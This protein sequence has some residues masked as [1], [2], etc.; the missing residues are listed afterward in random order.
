MH[1]C[2]YAYVA[3]YSEVMT[4]SYA[5]YSLHIYHRLHHEF[6]VVPLQIFGQ[7][8]RTGYSFASQK[9][10]RTPVSQVPETL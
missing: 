5:L 8:H 9:S 1:I 6:T 7:L 3:K 2:N 4:G 10:T